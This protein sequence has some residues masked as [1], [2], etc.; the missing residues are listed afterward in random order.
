MLSMAKY[1][2]V[3]LLPLVNYH[4][5]WSYCHSVDISLCDVSGCEGN[6]YTQGD[7][8]SVSFP[9]PVDREIVVPVILVA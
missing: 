1:L 6:G 4:A 3:Q 5:I 8:S 9:L 7:R 2:Q